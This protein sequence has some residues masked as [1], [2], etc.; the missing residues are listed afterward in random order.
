MSSLLISSFCW[1]TYDNCH[2]KDIQ[3]IIIY[4]QKTRVLKPLRQTG[5]PES[6]VLRWML[7]YSLTIELLWYL[8]QAFSCALTDH[9]QTSILITQI[10]QSWFHASKLYLQTQYKPT[11]FL[12]IACPSEDILLTQLS[13]ID[14]SSQYATDSKKCLTFVTTNCNNTTVPHNAF[15]N[16]SQLQDTQACLSQKTFLLKQR[17]FKIF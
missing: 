12:V 16:H 5:W 6:L 4:N 2:F 14:Q 13:S 10:W 8:Y 15:A 9:L 3:S 7:H 17:D 1:L 11:T